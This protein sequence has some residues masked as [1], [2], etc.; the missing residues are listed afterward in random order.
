[1]EI[2]A[3]KRD[4]NKTKTK[5]LRKEGEIP[6]IIFSKNSSKGKDP[7]IPITINLKEFKKMYAEVGESS[8]VSINI[9]DEKNIK[10]LIAEVQKH[11]ITLLPIHISFF[12]VDLTQKIT[13]NVPVEI[14]NEE[15]C[16]AV[17]S[18]KGI[19]ITVL[20]EIEVECLPANIPHTIQLDVKDLKEVGDFLTIK[21]VIK[22]VDTSIVEVKH[23]KDEAVVKVDYAEQLEVEEEE[24]SIEEVE[25]TT[26][27]KEET[28][29][30]GENVDVEPEPSKKQESTTETEK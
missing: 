21:N 25:V 14:I 9:D 29:A 7:T 1:M 22:S 3:T 10:A 18:G 24:T 12:Q 17:K 4:I 15:H 28:D 26:E 11:P 13:A 30:E 6:A 23:D 19:I 2:H 5:S 20:N 8:L 27:K 16:E